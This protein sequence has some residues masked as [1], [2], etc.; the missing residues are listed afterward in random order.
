[1]LS[2]TW[3][4]EDVK[5]ALERYSENLS[6]FLARNR[7]T[8]CFRTEIGASCVIRRADFTLRGPKPDAPGERRLVRE[9]LPI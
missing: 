4:T 9:R 5:G 7:R 2:A 6:A 1:M 3:G 8:E